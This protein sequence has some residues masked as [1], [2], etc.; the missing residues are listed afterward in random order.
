MDT[1]QDRIY[2]LSQAVV[3]TGF[4]AGKF[5]YNKEKLTKAGVVISDEGWRIPHSSLA[6]LG[7]LGVKAPRGVI[8][9]PSPLERAE[10]RVKELEAENAN[11]RK[12]LAE[13]PKKRG[14]FSR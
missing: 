11:L 9:P 1:P 14:L 4:S 2:S 3:A 6:K 13:K 12:Q 10:L 7:W 8:A 5:R